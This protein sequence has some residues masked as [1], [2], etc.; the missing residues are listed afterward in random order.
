MKFTPIF[1]YQS[2][3]V[4]PLLN[5]VQSNITIEKVGYSKKTQISVAQITAKDIR[6]MWPKLKKITLSI[7]G[8]NSSKCHQ[9]FVTKIPTNASRHLWTKNSKGSY[10]PVGKILADDIRLLYQA[11]GLCSHASKGNQILE[12]KIQAMAQQM[13][14]DICGLAYDIRHLWLKFSKWHH[15]KGKIW[16]NCIIGN[17]YSLLS[18]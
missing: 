4:F 15:Q 16:S 13:T 7:C 3:P 10:T 1:H 11:L 9:T 14:L 6:N 18:K 8:Q 2:V 5:I 12:A 17:F